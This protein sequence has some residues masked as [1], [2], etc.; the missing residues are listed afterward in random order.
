[1][2]NTGVPAALLGVV[3]TVVAY[4][5]RPRAP[6]VAGSCGVVSNVGKPFQLIAKFRDV[7]VSGD[8]AVFIHNFPMLPGAP[9]VHVPALAR[10]FP[11]VRAFPGSVHGR[12]EPL[13]RLPAVTP[14][15]PD[16][17][18]RRH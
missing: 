18:K 13:Q 6:A 15:E 7:S 9:V 16:L 8:P 12:M 11:V 17:R 4:G 14:V 10:D 5:R 3:G 2:G 1:M